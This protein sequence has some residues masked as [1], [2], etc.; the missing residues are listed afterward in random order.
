M[1]W[2][3]SWLA[4]IDQRDQYIQVRALLAKFHHDFNDEIT[5]LPG[6]YFSP[7]YNTRQEVN[8]ALHEGLAIVENIVGNGYRPKSVIAGF[9]S[10]ANMDFLAQ[11][12]GIHV[13]QGNIW[14]QHNIDY[15]DG[16]GSVSYPYY[17][18]KEHFLKPAQGKADFIDCVNRDG[19]T[20]D[21][22]AA[23]TDGFSHGDS[24]MGLGPIESIQNHG[25]EVGLQEQLHTS[26]IHYDDGFSRNGFGWLTAIWEVALGSLPNLLPALVTYGAKVRD[27]WPNVQAVTV[28]E[29]GEAW[30]A[31]YPDNSKW[32][33]QFDEVGSGIEGSDINVEIYWFM[34]SDFRLALT[35]DTKPGSPWEVID[36]T[37]YDLPA[38]EP[39][40]AGPNKSVREWSLMNKINQKQTRGAMDAPR[41][42]QQLSQADLKLIHKHYPELLAKFN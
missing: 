5:V 32:D 15:G 29:F 10:A 33:Y 6:G 3:V 38:Q 20:V 22:V 21:F 28:G 27:R 34:N 37:R 19:W 9:M 39:Q 36:F 35:R 1:T 4:L 11:H 25:L 40:D 16:D 24:R 12:E 30:R 14:S 31:H 23:R 18:S 42:L 2:A 26:S 41:P 8:D 7:M 13:C 17:P